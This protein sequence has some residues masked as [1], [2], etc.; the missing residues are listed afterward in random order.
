MKPLL[1]LIALCVASSGVYGQ[2]TQT[3]EELI[4]RP[5]AQVELTIPKRVFGPREPIKFRVTLI[6]V[7][8]RGF[9]ISKQFYE[10]GGGIAGFD[11][12]VTQLT[13]KKGGE[14]CAASAAD[15]FGIAADPRTPEQILKEDFVPIRPGAF[16][17]W[18][19]EYQRCKVNN[20][21]EYEISA[22]YSTADLYQGRVRNLVIN[23]QRVLDG[24]FKSKKVR[25]EVR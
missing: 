20:P 2:A 4:P 1:L 15:R 22:A 24:T 14:V 16:V 17:G 19:G 8:P 7:D 10:E 18:S 23:R 21:G 5:R 11:I 9:Y 13:G 6:N 3:P 25:F 12:T